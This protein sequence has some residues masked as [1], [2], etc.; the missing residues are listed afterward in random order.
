M[1]KQQ[2]EA[3]VFLMASEIR[4]SAK[5]LGSL[6]L[7]GFCP[8]CFWIQRRVEGQLPYQIFPGIFSSIDSYGKRLVHGWF[9]R[10]HTAPPWLAGLGAIKGYRPPP[11]F[12]KF[13]AHDPETSILLAGSPDGILIRKDDSY[14]IIDYKTA[15]FTAQ[16]DELFPMYE[17]Q[18]NAYA[19]IGG[20]CGLSPVSGLALVY[21]EPVTDVDAAEKEAHMTDQG[22]LIEFSAHIVP[23]D[24]RPDLVPSLLR[25]VREILDREHPPKALEGCADCARLE[26]L[27]G[28]VNS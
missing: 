13:N 28:V 11:H 16:Q 14:V 15:K 27:L 8:C 4:I 2:F 12:S 7:P 18:L 6:A 19:Y 22:F 25:R 5:T 3:Q 21:T 23:V 1:G 9:D 26:S 20:R 10:H 24:L 17:G